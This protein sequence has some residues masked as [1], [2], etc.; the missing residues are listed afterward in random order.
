MSHGDGKLLLAMKIIIFR[1]SIF[2]RPMRAW[3]A[4]SKLIFIRGKSGWVKNRTEISEVWMSQ[5]FT[6]NKK[7]FVISSR[8]RVNAMA[9]ID[10]ATGRVAEENPFAFPFTIMIGQT[11]GSCLCLLKQSWWRSLN[12]VNLLSTLTSLGWQIVQL[13]LAQDDD[14][15]GSSSYISRRA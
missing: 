1:K 5:L 8:Y 4:M 11:F 15:G 9:S 13:P 7:S 10:W 2:L 14:S 12:D 3:V 6:T